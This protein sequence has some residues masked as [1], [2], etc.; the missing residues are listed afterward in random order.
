[1]K[2]AFL[3]SKHCNYI[4]VQWLHLTATK[5][6]LALPCYGD[7]KLTNGRERDT[8]RKKES[9]PQA[10]AHLLSLQNEFAHASHYQR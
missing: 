6:G 4:K 10:L 9:F 1:M 5:I 3:Y 8:K 7:L 2:E